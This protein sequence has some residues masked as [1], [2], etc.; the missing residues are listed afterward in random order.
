M[1]AAFQALARAETPRGT[2]ALNAIQRIAGAI[3]TAG[4]AILL[5][6]SSTA[7]LPGHADGVQA[8]AALSRNPGAHT[9]AILASAHTRP[10]NVDGDTQ[11]LTG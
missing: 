6:R 9:A 3:A 8:I 10:P 1:A 2:S 11:M 5:Q 4:F 7:K